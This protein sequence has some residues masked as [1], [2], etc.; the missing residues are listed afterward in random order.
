MFKKITNFFKPKK[1]VPS[2][3][4]GQAAYV[5]WLRRY[6]PDYEK[7][8]QADELGGP[9]GPEPTRYRTWERGGIDVDF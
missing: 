4:R 6:H 5:E 3:P 8:S 9:R 1:T 2:P 7:P